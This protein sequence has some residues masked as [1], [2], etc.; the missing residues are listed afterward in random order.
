M[1]ELSQIKILR[2]KSLIVA[3]LA[4]ENKEFCKALVGTSVKF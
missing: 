4:L 1:G 3:S 2:V